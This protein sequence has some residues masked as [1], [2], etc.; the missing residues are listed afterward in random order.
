MSFLDLALL[1]DY[2]EALAAE[3]ALR[4]EWPELFR[5]PAGGPLFVATPTEPA[6]WWDRDVKRA[7]KGARPLGGAGQTGPSVAAR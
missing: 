1:R 3:R 7:L 4:R 5:M 2:V 6:T